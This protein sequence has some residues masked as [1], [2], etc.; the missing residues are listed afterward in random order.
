[1]LIH[2][3]V[4][5]LDPDALLDVRSLGVVADLVRE[6]LRLAER[7]HEGGASS[8]GST[9]TTEIPSVLREGGDTRRA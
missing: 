2:T 6:H 3:N 7:V 8:A 9:Y 4:D 5:R 1:M